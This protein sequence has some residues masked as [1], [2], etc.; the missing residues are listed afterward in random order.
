MTWLMCL[1]RSLRIE[2]PHTLSKCGIEGAERMTNS[3]FERTNSCLSVTGCPQS[4]QIPTNAMNGL[5]RIFSAV[6]GSFSVGIAADLMGKF[7]WFLHHPRRI[8][9]PLGQKDANHLAHSRHDG[10]VDRYCCHLNKVSCSGSAWCRRLSA[11]TILQKRSSS[12][13]RCRNRLFR[14]PTIG[15]SAEQYCNARAISSSSTC[16]R[17]SRSK[18]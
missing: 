18:M 11:I 10:R 2:F 12:S 14:S 3:I 7:C 9:A 13:L 1:L 17:R 5:R 15:S 6:T 16:C 8:L 4:W